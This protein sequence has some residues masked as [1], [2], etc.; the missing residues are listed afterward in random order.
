MR[1]DLIRILT[2]LMKRKKK[3]DAILVE[4]TG[5][6]DPAPVAQT[7]FVDDDI[8]A[9]MRLD[10]ILTIVDSKHIIQHLDEKKEEG[11]INESGSG[12]LLH[13]PA[14]NCS[15]PLPQEQF[16]FRCWPPDARWHAEGSDCLHRCSVQQIA[17]ADRILLNKIDLVDAQEKEDIK[18]RIRVGCCR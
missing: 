12:H 1:G 9:G 13:R 4:T 5:L 17:F 10:S 6:A 2:K 15:S 14:P 18:E 11:I 16:S 8:K 3:L 7:F